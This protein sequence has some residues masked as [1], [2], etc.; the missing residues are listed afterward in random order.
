MRELE[1]PLG[2]VISL[3]SPPD[4]NRLSIP[5]VQAKVKSPRGLRNKTPAGSSFLW[6]STHTPVTTE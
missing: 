6:L 1:C 3:T 5:L 2:S 4:Y